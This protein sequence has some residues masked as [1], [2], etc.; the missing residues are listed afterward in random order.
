MINWKGNNSGKP[1]TINDQSIDYDYF[2]LFK[3]EIIE[4]RAFSKEFPN[5]D[6]CFILNE[7]AVKLTGFSSPIGRLITVWK[8]E[9]RIIGVVKNFHSSSFHEKI[10]PIVFMLSERHGPRTILFVKLKTHDISETLQYIKRQA[11]HFAPN[12]QF[13]YAF[14]DEI[15]ADQYAK[16]QRRGALYRIFTIL[17]VIISCLGLYGLVSSI[18]SG[19]T[20]EIGIR[21]VLGATVTKITTLLLKEFVILIC[22]STFIGWSVSY[23]VIQSILNNYAYKTSMSFWIFFAAWILILFPAVLSIAGK[24]V[25]AALINPVDSL[26][27]E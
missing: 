2:D 9:G 19:K 3:M 24:V 11:A 7:E 18:L 6:E 5:D 8:K 21:K 23:F 20:K 15:F 12:N 27:H 17:A 22:I 25:K 4:G 1:I 16:D 26:K 10:K 13:E 14:L